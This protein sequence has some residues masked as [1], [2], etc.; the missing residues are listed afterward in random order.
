MIATMVVDDHRLV[1]EAVVQLLSSQPD[2]SVVGAAEDAQTAVPLAR[3]AGPDVVVMD[4]MMPGVDGIA[5]TRSLVRAMPL[6]KVVILSATCTPLLV[7]EAFRAGACGYLL[8]DDPAGDLS[9]AVRRAVRG[10]QPMT[11]LARLWS[12]GTTCPG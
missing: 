7:R 12:E 1:R 3:E 9:D 10:E 8:K 5:A 4:L 6:L 11:P 2:I